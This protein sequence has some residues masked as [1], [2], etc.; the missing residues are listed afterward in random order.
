MNDTSDIMHA[1]NHVTSLRNTSDFR[2][3]HQETPSEPQW[4]IIV[5]FQYIKV[6]GMLVHCCVHVPTRTGSIRQFAF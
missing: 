3:S 1:A 2:K 5:R 4:H 6:T